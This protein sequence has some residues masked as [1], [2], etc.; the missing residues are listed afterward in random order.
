MDWLGRR[1]GLGLVAGGL[2]CL[3]LVCLGLG[4][5]A[6]PGLPRSPTLNL[7]AEVSDLTALRR[8]DGV[9]LRF[10]VPQRNTDK[11]PYKADAVKV[12][13]CRAVSGG[14]CLAV[15]S[16]E[17]FARLTAGKATVAVLR[18]RL[19]AALTVGAARLLAYRVELLNPAGKTAGYGDAAYTAAGAGLAAVEGLEAQGSRL[20]I[21]VSWKAMARDA[22]EIAL[23]REELAP[24]PAVVKASGDR[25][26]KAAGGGKA[27]MPVAKKIDV[28]EEANVVWLGVMPTQGAETRVG[29]LLDATAEEEEPYRYSAER[30]R[31]AQLGG[32][33]VEM[34]SEVSAGVVYTLHDVYAPPAPVDLSAAAFAVSNE[35]PAQGF[36]VDL[37][38]QPVED[39]GLAGYNVYRQA[40]DAGG[41]AMGA[42]QRLNSAPVRVPGYHDVLPASVQGTRFRYSVTAADAKGNESAASETVLETQ[43]Y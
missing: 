29:M 37:I 30:R 43:K 1:C 13:L 17:S 15:G 27:K 35:D 5:C 40:L 42:R 11:L 20:G 28:G 41:A 31:V 39:A 24:K 2:V 9:E 36:A 7:P 38:W 18:D 33:S 32:R 21:V 23:R 14:A 34:R 19:P 10:T 16:Q 8:G 12:G 25:G 26:G 22:E 3:G 6:S 4:G